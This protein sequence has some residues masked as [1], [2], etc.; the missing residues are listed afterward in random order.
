MRVVSQNNKKPL[1]SK[2]YTTDSVINFIKGRSLL[3]VLIPTIHHQI[4]QNV[5]FR[6]RH[7]YNRTKWGWSKT[8]DLFDEI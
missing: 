6:Q 5:Q 1:L 2:F 3:R 4:F 8:N 7:G